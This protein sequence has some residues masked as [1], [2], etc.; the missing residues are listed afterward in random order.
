MEIVPQ[1]P[2]R[3]FTMSRT[4]LCVLTASLLVIVCVS[5]MVARTAILGDEVKLPGGPGIWKITMLVQGKT[6]ADARIWTA[7]P[8]DLNHQ[9]LLR[10]IARSDELQQKPSEHR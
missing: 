1:S 5:I 3:G 9:H 7:T 4:P 10:E 6:S 8:L 2:S